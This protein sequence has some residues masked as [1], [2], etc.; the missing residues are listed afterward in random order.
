MLRSLFYHRGCHSTVLAQLILVII[1]MVVVWSWMVVNCLK[2]SNWRMT[3]SVY[4][5]IA[6][7]MIIRI[8]HINATN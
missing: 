2:L 3:S 1:I 6:A 4:S 8:T 7:V 5:V